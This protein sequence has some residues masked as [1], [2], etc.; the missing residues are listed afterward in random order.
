MLERESFQEVPGPH[1]ICCQGLRPSFTEICLL[2]DTMLG[3]GPAV[4]SIQCTRRP[5]GG[6]HWPYLTD[7]ETEAQGSLVTCPR[8]HSQ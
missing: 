4:S 1:S 7:E 8:S 6:G 2:Q 3:A 5:R